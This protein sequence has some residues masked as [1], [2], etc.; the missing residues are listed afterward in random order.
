MEK[1]TTW[2]RQPHS[3]AGMS[4]A[5]AL[6][7]A[8]AG[9]CATNA[10]ANDQIAASQAAITRASAMGANEFAPIEM[11]SARDRMVRANEAVA[12]REYV[13]ANA[14]SQEALKDVQLAEVKVQSEKA[15]RAAMQL[16]EDR[17]VLQNE[18][19]RNTQ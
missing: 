7:M 1:T 15:Q 12:A 2:W 9:G 14:L 10:P 16:R 11:K 6:L 8:A 5:L 18:I 19:Q 4:L 13:L 17:R 3:R